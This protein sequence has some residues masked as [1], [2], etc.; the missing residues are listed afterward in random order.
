MRKKGALLFATTLLIS[1]LC[2]GC[3]EPLYEL[4]AQEEAL[5]VQYSAATLAK[6]NV[7]QKDGQKALP[8]SVIDEALYEAP[9]FTEPETEA[10][11][12][13]GFAVIP[14]EGSTVIPEEQPHGPAENLTES[15]TL[16]ESIGQSGTLDVSFENYY[17]TDNYKE[18]NYYFVDASAGKRYLVVQYNLTNISGQDA[19]LDLA[20]LGLTYYVSVN[21]STWI[22]EDITFSLINLST[23]QGII[24]AG[25]S[26]NMVSLFQIDKNLEGNISEISLAVGQ[27]G[28]KKRI[29]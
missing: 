25:K 13:D 3:G 10:A 6:Y 7:Y 5:I 17:V 29:F 4:T 11:E 12:G 28:T 22:P 19:T 20:G 1:S 26:V 21:G 18:G 2:T 15:T 16:A 8:A 27:N 14:G 23:Y 9:S 24:P